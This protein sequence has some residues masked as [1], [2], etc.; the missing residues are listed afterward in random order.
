MAG[1]ETKFLNLDEVDV[2]V[3]N[4]V[5]KLD[6]IE[7]K[8]TPITLRDWIANTKMM[9]ELRA[10]SGDMEAEANVIINM[11][12]RSFKTLTADM[13][14][15]MPLVKLNKI[16]E[17]ARSHN[18]EKTADEEVEAEAASHPLAVPAAAPPVVDPALA[19]LIERVAV[20]PISSPK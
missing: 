18:G 5:I 19:T 9:Q 6:Q 7:H 17:F 12:T 10:G 20:Q 3:D 2:E 15:D 13:L 8:L 16:L 1:K 11:I 14:K 4:I